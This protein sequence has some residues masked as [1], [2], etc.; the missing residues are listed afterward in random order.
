MPCVMTAIPWG[1]CAEKDSEVVCGI[2]SVGL[3]PDL[4]YGQASRQDIH[5][6][7]VLLDL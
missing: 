1:K 6:N 3:I 4:G 7:V 2:S 5:K